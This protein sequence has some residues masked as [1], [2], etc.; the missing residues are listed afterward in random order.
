MSCLLP[1]PLSVSLA[2][3][4]HGGRDDVAAVEAW[5]EQVNASLAA[6]FGAP[7][8]WDERS[9]Q[10]HPRVEL[11]ATALCGVRLLAVYADRPDLDLPDTLAA[12]ASRDP[13]YAAAL[14]ASFA[15]SRYGQLLAARIWLPGDFAFTFVCPAPHGDDVAFGSLDVLDDQLRRLNER[16]LVAPREALA[17]AAS[18]DDSRSVGFVD[19]ALAGLSRFVVCAAWSRSR[20]LP[21]VLV[22]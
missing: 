7:L 5:R 22:D 20:A 17:A 3:D 13:V 14:A 6:R 12:D 8:R 21:L 15:S 1:G 16:T 9:A 2:P 4:A 18:R 11:S 19:A 10:R